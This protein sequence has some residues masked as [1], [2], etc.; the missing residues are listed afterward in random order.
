[1]RGA[2]KLLLA[3]SVAACV[4]VVVGYQSTRAAAGLSNPRVFVPKVS[5]YQRFSPAMRVTIGD[6]YWLFAVQYYGEH[7]D[8][9]HRLDSLPATLDVV[10]SMSPRFKQAYF[11][12]AFALLD[13]GRPD[14]GYALLE[15][16]FKANPND[17]H[18]PFYLGFFA[19]TFA[20]NKDKDRIAAQWYAKAAALPGHLPSVERLAADLYT[21]GNAKGKAI[22][23]WAQ[24]YGQGDKYAR[25]KA[26]AALDRLLP[27]AKTAREKA[28][29]GLKDLMPASRFDQFIADV[30]AGYL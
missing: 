29:A 20:S 21:K 27:R 13:A 28:V 16:G 4:A 6:V 3:L 19:Y 30:F 1:M 8:T 24:V 25:D 5:F 26:V 14:L 7:V 11:F 17:W 15:R 23:L 22:E 2:R 18:F 9:D 10:T 12:G